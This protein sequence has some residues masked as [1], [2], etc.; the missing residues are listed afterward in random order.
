M[1]VPWLLIALVGLAANEVF[2]QSE[3]DFAHP[4]PLPTAGVLSCINN[5]C[6]NLTRKILNYFNFIGKLYM[7][8]YLYD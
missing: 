3:E 5:A 7:L 4:P 2:C 8:K 6:T 1:A